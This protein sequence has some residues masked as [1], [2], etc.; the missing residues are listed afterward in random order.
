MKNKNDFC[1]FCFT[2]QEDLVNAICP[3]CSYPMKGSKAQQDQFIASNEKLKQKI[4][5]AETA[6]SQARFAMLWPSLTAILLSF[7]FNFPPQNMLRF[8]ITL[9]FYSIFVFAYFLV[10][11]KPFPILLLAAMVLF[12]GILFSMAYGIVPKMLLIVPGV[13]WLIYLNGIYSVWRAEKALEIKQ[14]YGTK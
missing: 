2:K 9:G 4:D 8:A 6:L 7:G 10:A 11:W 12:T 5:E 3:V 1:E 13:I 14:Q